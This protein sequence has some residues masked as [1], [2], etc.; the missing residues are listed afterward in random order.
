MKRIVYLA[1][2]VIVILG[3]AHLTA[4]PSFAQTGE[5]KLDAATLKSTIVGLGYEVKDTITT[6]GKEKYEFKI[7]KGDLSIP[8]GAEL[9]GSKNYIWLTVNLG[10]DSG[11]LNY[12]EIL[13][14]NAKIQP[15]FFYIASNGSV[16][17]A[18]AIDN[19]Q[20]SATVFRRVIDKLS[21]DVVDTK[22]VWQAK[23]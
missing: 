8:I 1:C 5:A 15:S 20:A 7:E 22:D 17:L 11:K 14:R 21:S 12:Q 10:T 9:S 19:R 4:V 2:F 6:P 3:F 16:M 23:E 13:K 18:E